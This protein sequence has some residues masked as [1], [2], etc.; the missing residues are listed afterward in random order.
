LASLRTTFL[1]WEPNHRVQL[2]NA[3]TGLI[4]MQT[5]IDGSEVIRDSVLE[6]DQCP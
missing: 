4:N 3:P 2:P 6:K 1:D 5:M